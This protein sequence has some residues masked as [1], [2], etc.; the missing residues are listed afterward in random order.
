MPV[1]PKKYIDQLI[2][3]LEREGMF[4]DYSFKRFFSTKTSR[5]CTKYTIIS[6]QDKTRKL[7]T[8]NKIEILKYLVREF[9]EYKGEPVPEEFLV[10]FDE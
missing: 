2:K 8:Y 7:E 3:A 5:Y 4:Y 6:K 10:P 9:K 1:N